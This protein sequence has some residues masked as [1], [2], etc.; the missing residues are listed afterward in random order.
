MFYFSKIASDRRITLF[1]QFPDLFIRWRNAQF[2]QGCWHFYLPVE[3]FHRRNACLC[4]LLFCLLRLHTHNVLCKLH[5]SFNTLPA[6]IACP[7]SPDRG[8]P[9]SMCHIK[10]ST[11]LVF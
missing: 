11:K 7:A 2:C 10:H 8:K 5:K 9:C 1:C 4:R 6:D 3:I